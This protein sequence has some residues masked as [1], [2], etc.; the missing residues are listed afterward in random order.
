SKKRRNE[1]P[2]EAPS[3]ADSWDAEDSMSGSSSPAPIPSPRFSSMN[4]PPRQE[5][6]YNHS[7]D[8]PSEVMSGRG[9]IENPRRPQPHPYQ[10]APHSVQPNLY[11]PQAFDSPDNSAGWGTQSSIPHPSHPRAY[12]YTYLHPRGVTSQPE[13][14]QYTM[15]PMTSDYPYYSTPPP[16]PASPPPSNLKHERDRGDE[17]TARRAHSDHN[18]FRKAKPQREGSEHVNA[19]WGGFPMECD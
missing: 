18:P 5:R 10:T 9:H 2:Y 1:A 19:D 17:G 6:P 16:G 14:G 13:I 3:D 7:R 8:I 4:S 11:H 15:P 12:E